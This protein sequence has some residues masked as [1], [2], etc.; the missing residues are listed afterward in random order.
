M[1]CVH[2]LRGVWVG[3]CLEFGM[4]CIQ[5][6]RKKCIEELCG[7]SRM[8]EDIKSAGNCHTVSPGQEFSQQTP[9]CTECLQ[10]PLHIHEESLKK[11]VLFTH[12]LAGRIL[13]R[14]EKSKLFNLLE[15]DS[16]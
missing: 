9:L 15:Q 16:A 4:H 14:L 11:P 13:V 7:F 3:H 5:Y 6:G 1:E 2:G 8:R 12:A 10:M